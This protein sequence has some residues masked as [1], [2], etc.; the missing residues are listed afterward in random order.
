MCAKGSPA[1]GGIR[2]G[3]KNP[4]GDLKSVILERIRRSFWAGFP[5]HFEPDC[6]VIFNWIPRSL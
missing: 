4:L 3:A 5:G 1:E 2:L 6:A